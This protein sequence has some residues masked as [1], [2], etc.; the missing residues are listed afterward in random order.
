MGKI[1]LL[2]YLYS[3]V[4]INVRNVD[5]VEDYQEINKYI[6]DINK[7]VKSYLSPYYRIIKEINL[8]SCTTTQEIDEKIDFYKHK[9]RVTSDE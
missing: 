9:L 4:D 2:E 7:N 3:I 5:D 8:G 6:D 1:E